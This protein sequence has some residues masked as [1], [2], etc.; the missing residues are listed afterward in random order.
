MRAHYR[1]DPRIILWIII[2]YESAR[3]V[4]TVLTEDVEG[5]NEENKV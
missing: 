1:E 5:A 4:R 3:A 2:Y